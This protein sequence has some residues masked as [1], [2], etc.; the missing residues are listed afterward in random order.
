MP[1]YILEAVNTF[2]S[3]TNIPTIGPTTK[4]LYLNDFIS[5][6][7]V[8]WKFVVKLFVVVAV[9]ATQR[10]NCVFYQMFELICDFIKVKKILMNDE[11]LNDDNEGC[12]YNVSNPQ[13]R[14]PPPGAR[15]GAAFPLRSL[16]AV[17]SHGQH[18]CTLLRC[19]SIASIFSAYHWELSLYIKINTNVYNHH[20]TTM[21]RLSMKSEDLFYITINELF[22]CLDRETHLACTKVRQ[23]SFASLFETLNFISLKLKFILKIKIPCT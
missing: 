3:T 21:T 5:V 2:P 20:R 19:V 7:L 23:L 8:F 18:E 17:P 22:L 10:E 6:Q 16:R 4:T 12:K 13:H 14:P 15:C 9:S 1:R 11:W